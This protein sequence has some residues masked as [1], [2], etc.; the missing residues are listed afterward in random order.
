MSCEAVHPE[1]GAQCILGGGN[2]QSHLCRIEGMVVPIQ[3]DNASYVAPAPKKKWTPPPPRAKSKEE[4]REAQQAANHDAATES[5]RWAK[6]FGDHAFDNGTETS[7]EAAELVKPAS[8]SMRLRIL[9]AII[10]AASGITD[11]MLEHRL[12]MKHQTASARRRELVLAGM[13]EANG[14]VMNSSGAM[15]Q[16][17]VATEEGHRAFEAQK[18]KMVS[19]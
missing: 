17:W 14:K 19:S 16:T 18:G 10:E 2:H 4:L 12:Q 11:E 3:W 9:A 6:L 5:Q 1:Y 8:G 15:A 7:A 13:I